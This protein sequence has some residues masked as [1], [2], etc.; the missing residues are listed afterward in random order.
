MNNTNVNRKIILLSFFF[1]YI[2]TKV[3]MRIVNFIQLFSVVF[4]HSNSGSS[5][6]LIKP[7]SYGGIPHRRHSE[8]LISAFRASVK[9]H[10]EAVVAKL[11]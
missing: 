7:N 9:F 3:N 11:G 5:W 6:L 8:S 10:M 2:Q 1:N 4:V